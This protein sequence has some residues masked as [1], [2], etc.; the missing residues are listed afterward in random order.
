MTLASTRRGRIVTTVPT[1]DD[2]H[3]GS[4]VHPCTLSPLRLHSVLFSSPFPFETSTA[5][6]TG[7]TSG[8]GWQTALAL[9][10]LGCHVVAGGRRQERLEQLSEQ[11]SDR[12]VT[13]RGDL[14]D[15][16]HREALLQAAT[17]NPEHPLRL[18]VNNAG[19]GAIGPFAEADEKR[20]RTIMEI[21]F[22]AVAELTR[23]SLSELSK[24]EHAT[25]CNVGSVLGHRAVGDKSEYCASKFAL[26]GWNDAM[27]IEWAGRV[28]FVHVCPSTTRSEFFDSLVDTDPATKSRSFGS[29]SPQ[30]VADSIVRAIRH[31]KPEKI[32]SLGGKALVYADRFFPTLLGWIL[33]RSGRSHD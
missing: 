7:A 12:L 11:L 24:S 18:L 27:A 14:N 21:N 4:A 6:V 26:H 19:V 30:R 25:V 20:L 10:R 2:T 32:L 28:K 13:V 17:Q 23:A 5:I 33:R 8:I 3:A 1:I 31:G 9:D 29:Q 15:V 16:D 22:F